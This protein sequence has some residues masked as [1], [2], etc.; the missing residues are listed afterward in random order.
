MI[1]RI[2]GIFLICL[3][4]ACGRGDPASARDTEGR[5]PAVDALEDPSGRLTLDEV[6]RASGWETLTG[7][8]NFGYT[9]SAYWL[10]L[11]PEM[12]ETAGDEIL[13][14]IAYPILDDVRAYELAGGASSVLFEGG[15]LLPFHQRP[16]L[17]RDFV[18]PAAA[19]PGARIYI[20]V[21]SSSSLQVPVS[22]WSR[23][24][25]FHALGTEN[26]ILGAYFGVLCVMLLFNLFLYFSVRDLSY[27]FYVLSILTTG[28][29]MSGL[30]GLAFEFLWPNF[31]RWQQIALPVSLFAGL[32]SAA[33][34][35]VSFLKTRSLLPGLHKATIVLGAAG[36]SGMILSPL[37]PM[38]GLLLV[39]NL[40]ALCLIC[41]ILVSAFL[42]IRQGYAPA[43]YFLIA[44]FWF[45]GGSCVTVLRTLGIAP[46]NAFS[47]YAAYLGSAAELILFSMALGSRIR[48]IRHEREDA[49]RLALLSIQRADRL[50]DELLSNVS[51][52]LNTPLAS[53]MANAEM[54]QSGDWK[55]EE[56]SEVFRSI[57]KDSAQLARQVNNLMLV[58]KIGSRSLR[59]APETISLHRIFSRIKEQMDMEF[60][61]RTIEISGPD[62]TINADPV[63]IQAAIGEVIRNGLMFS[64]P[65]ARV[66][67]SC[68]KAASSVEVE[69][70]DNGPGIPEHAIHVVTGRFSRL[71]S[72][73][74]Y[75][76]SGIGMGLYVAVQI[77]ETLGGDLDL[78]NAE[79]GGL[80]AVFRFPGAAAL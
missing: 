68:R 2:A 3:L 70:R 52:E 26:Y 49:Q 31:V 57:R 72:S 55:P 50:Q 40:L 62:V 1:S 7:P 10:R 61:D 36:G 66:V 60:S 8:P 41:V 5:L 13:V 73:L 75:R 21:Q 28:L 38:R 69:V 54:L 78:R 47:L 16:I 22:I 25:F 14:R 27:L 71:D 24:G 67:A 45:L 29:F 30:N 37:L 48:L 56:Q 35:S 79:G 59:P 77:A 23:A 19:K 6:V 17:H 80:S 32:C 34:F 12:P 76:E 46:I 64:G 43:R 63:L 65:G 44:W 18:F 39:F 15:D 58:T 20:R 4:S 33:A 11:D 42:A 74:T 51:H 9:S 53:I